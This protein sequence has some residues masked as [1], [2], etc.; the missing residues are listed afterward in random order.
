[1]AFPTAPTNGQIATVNG[2]RYSYSAVS[3]SWTRISSGKFTAAATGPTN[4]STGDHWYNT[5]E[6]VLYEW[7]YDGTN[8]YWID[9]SS[10]FVG[11][12]VGNLISDTIIAGNLIPSANI[13]Y[14]LGSSS[15]RFKD[16]WLSGN[17]IILGAANISTDA[18]GSNVSFGSAN[19][20]TIGGTVI[21][22]AGNTLTITNPGGGIFAV[23]GNTV[24][25]LT[26]ST[27]GNIDVTGNIT[28]TN[29]VFWANGAPFTS[30]PSGVAIAMSIVFGSS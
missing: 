9:I 19:T 16:L 12:N 24:T 25:G 26:T 14:S 21:N 20:L 4:P 28:T 22:S 17:T 15:Y 11:G 5:A 3:N 27:F 6:D 13:T 29:G 7:T 8:Y 10:G 1:M 30:D 18:A 23:T 2:I